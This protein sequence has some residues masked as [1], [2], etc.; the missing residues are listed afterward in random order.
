[1]SNPKVSIVIPVYNTEVFV[2]EAVRSIMDQTL[3]DTEIIIINDGST[4]TS[5]D[6]IQKLSEEDTRIQIYSQENQ[7][8]SATRNRGIALASGR[9]IYF[10]DSDDYLEPRPWRPV[11]INARRTTLI[12]FSSTRIS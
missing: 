4:D 2:E 8:L 12:L 9:Y 7:G 11:S 5:L 10:M 6:I 3:R 1:M